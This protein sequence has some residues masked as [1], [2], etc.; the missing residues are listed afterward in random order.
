MRYFK[1]INF[2]HLVLYLFPTFIFIC[3]FAVGLG[4]YY[5]HTKNSDRRMEEI[6]ETFPEG[7]QGRE[8]PFPL[9]VTLTIIG[10]IAWVVG[11]IIF[12]GITGVRF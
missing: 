11:Y 4:F 3:L 6:I 1:L 2:E 8:A 5:F 12:Y 10:T 9:V 7:I